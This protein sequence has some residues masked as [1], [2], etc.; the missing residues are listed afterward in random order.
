MLT[1]IRNIADPD[2]EVTVHPWYN[3]RAMR[4]GYTIRDAET[5]EAMFL[6]IPRHTSETDAK[7]EAAA[8]FNVVGE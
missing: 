1:R 3:R 2:R 8:Y 7:R 4:Y 5:R 6:G